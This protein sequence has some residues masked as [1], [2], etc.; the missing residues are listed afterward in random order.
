EGSATKDGL[1]AA[2]ADE[3]GEIGVALAELE[4]GDGLAA[5]AECPLEEGTELLRVDPLF[6]ADVRGLVDVGG[7]RHPAPSALYQSRRRGWFGGHRSDRRS[8]SLVKGKWFQA[9]G[10]GRALWMA[11]GAP[12][13]LHD[14]L[15]TRT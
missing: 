13:S 11:C 6:V 12:G 10:P 8:L 1:V 15:F 7:G 4:D 14:V 2:V 5:S 3:V 9:I